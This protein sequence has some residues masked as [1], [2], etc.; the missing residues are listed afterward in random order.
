[1]ALD[2]EILRQPL[3]FG[4]VVA[5][6]PQELLR[7]A[8]DR[9][10]C[11]LQEAVPDHRL[12][13]RLVH[14]GVKA[15]DDRRRGPG[16][17]ERAEPLIERELDA[18]LL[19]GRHVRQARRARRRAL[20][21][22]LEGAGL[23]VRDQRRRAERGD[24]DMARHQVVDRLGAAAIGHVL[25]PDAGELREPLGGHMLLRANSRGGIAQARPLLGQ[26]DQLGDRVDAE[27]GMDRQHHRLPRQLDDR[28][29]VLQR[30]ETHLEHVWCARHL[31]GRNQHRVAVRRAAGSGL[32]ADI[33]AAAGPVL[34]H[35]LL[36]ERA[37]QMIADD[38]GADVGRAAGGIWHD[39]AD[40]PVRPFLRL[41]GYWDC[42]NKESNENAP[43]GH[44]KGS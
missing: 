38:A 24:H 30:I 16:R 14:L 40:R 28:D 12:G 19:V 1:L 25:E 22:Q 2:V 11:R 4:K 27:L 20:R 39:E 43:S 6:E 26:R 33:T 3:V 10:L 31:V 37:R 41:R 36:A 9:L 21:D 32:E 15:R 17:H 42:Q 44:R 5:Q 34:H 18:R 8:A 35:D 29:Q 23:V 7:A 13:Q